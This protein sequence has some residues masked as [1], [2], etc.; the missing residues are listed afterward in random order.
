MIWNQWYYSWE[1]VGTLAFW[2]AWCLRIDWFV[3]FEL[4]KGGSSNLIYDKLLPPTTYPWLVS[5]LLW[6]YFVPFMLV[7]TFSRKYGYWILATHHEESLCQ[8]TLVYSILK[9]SIIINCTSWLICFSIICYLH[10][11]HDIIKAFVV[12]CIEHW[13]IKS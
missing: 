5:L 9:L 6:V 1:E 3:T 11:E 12:A 8:T 4:L 7:N 13:W 10:S 2:W